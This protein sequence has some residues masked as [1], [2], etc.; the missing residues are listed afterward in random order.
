VSELGDAL[1][2]AISRTC[3]VGTQSPI[4]LDDA[5]E[6]EPDLVLCHRVGRKPVAAEVL[7]VVEV[8]DSSRD[9][10]REIKLPRYARA[11]IPEFWLVDLTEDRVEVH[12][13][14]GPEG[15][16]ERRLVPATGTLPIPTTSVS[17]DLRPVFGI[18]A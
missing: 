7:L 16:A 4:T 2:R 13:R 1:T 9:F 5:N 12:T 15:Y 8:A 10:D 3:I 17:L 6:P 11:G 18:R 14:P